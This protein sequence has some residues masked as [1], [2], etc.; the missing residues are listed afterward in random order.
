MIFTCIGVCIY[1]RR[2]GICVANIRNPPS[3]YI[4][5]KTFSILINSHHPQ[6]YT[7]NTIVY[8]GI[9]CTYRSSSNISIVAIPIQGW[10]DKVFYTEPL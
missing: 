5:F 3:A 1:V 10:F 4:K 6:P 2:I 7:K 9:L 8:E